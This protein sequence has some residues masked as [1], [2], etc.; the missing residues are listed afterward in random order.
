MR[1]IRSINSSLKE[2]TNMFKSILTVKNRLSRPCVKYQVHFIF[3]LIFLGLISYLVL[4]IKPSLRQIN[5]KMIVHTKNL[6]CFPQGMS[7][8]RLQASRPVWLFIQVT[9]HIWIVMF[10]LEEFRQVS[11]THENKQTI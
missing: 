11:H 9:I 2:R 4:F 5:D 6:T 7:C 1:F 3:Y 8:S 10:A